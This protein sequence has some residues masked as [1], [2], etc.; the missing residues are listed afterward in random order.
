V[1][2]VSSKEGELPSIS[3]EGVPH[4]LLILSRF[5][6]IFKEKLLA[7]IVQGVKFRRKLRIGISRVI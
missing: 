5:K 1:L 7:P 3:L 4:I 6:C 2:R